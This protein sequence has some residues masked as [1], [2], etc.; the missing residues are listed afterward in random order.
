M[1]EKDMRVKRMKKRQ[2]GKY[3]GENM[4]REGRENEKTKIEKTE[5]KEGKYR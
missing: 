2:W 5:R 4:K 1:E 3:R